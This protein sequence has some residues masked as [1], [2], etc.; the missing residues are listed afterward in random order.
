M[1]IYFGN[2]NRFHGFVWSSNKE[3]GE[4]PTAYR[5]VFILPYSYFAPY[6]INPAIS[7][8]Y[9]FVGVLPGVWLGIYGEE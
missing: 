5:R 2:C 8:I 3:A 6:F 4:M 1:F 7:V 9:G